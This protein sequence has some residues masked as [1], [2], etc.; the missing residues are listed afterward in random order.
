[1]KENP[2]IVLKSIVKLKGDQE[3]FYENVSIV[4][5]HILVCKPH[6]AVC[7]RVISPC[8][9]VK[10]T[11]R[12]PLKRH[13]Y[14][15]TSIYIRMNTPP[16]SDFDPTRAT[17]QWMNKKS[18]GQETFQSRN[19]SAKFPCKIKALRTNR[20]KRKQKKIAKI[21]GNS[22]KNFYIVQSVSRRQS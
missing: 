13:L 6:F 22:S 8:N 7:E 19:G 10:S 3:I 11:C 18:I 20:L 1:M 16:L 4:L 17:L 5:G 15:T 9:K 12:L 14:A 2:H 21:L